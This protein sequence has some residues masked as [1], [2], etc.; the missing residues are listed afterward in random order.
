MDPFRPRFGGEVL[1]V[2]PAGRGASAGER[3]E[4]GFAQTTTEGFECD[5][6]SFE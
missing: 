2:D 3:L 5:V 1:Q 4:P 6:D